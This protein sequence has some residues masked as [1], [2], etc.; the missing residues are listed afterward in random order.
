M[1][2]P[3]VGWLV[4]K[5][6]ILVSGPPQTPPHFNLLRSRDLQMGRMVAVGTRI[7]PC[8]VGAYDPRRLSKLGIGH[9]AIDSGGGYT[10]LNP[11]TGH[12]L[13]GIAG[14]TYNFK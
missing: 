5:A 9:D 11:Q 3:K 2:I 8:P 6:P 4:S 7:S 13:S 1:P 14:F 10:G 12:K